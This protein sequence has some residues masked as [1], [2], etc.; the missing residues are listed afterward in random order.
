VNDCKQNEIKST[1]ALIV[2][3]LH[4]YRIALPLSMLHQNM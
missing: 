3:Y 1:V 2:S 4:P